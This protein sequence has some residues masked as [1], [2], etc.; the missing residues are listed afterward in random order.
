MPRE[1]VVTAQIERG[2]LEWLAERRGLF[3]SPDMTVLDYLSQFD[4]AS[5]NGKSPSWITTTPT[6]CFIRCGLCP[7]V[8]P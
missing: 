8:R 4:G 3:S 5:M 2:M 6:D 7:Q 1:H